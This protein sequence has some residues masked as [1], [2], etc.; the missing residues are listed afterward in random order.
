MEQKGYWVCTEKL[1][2]QAHRWVWI[3]HFG[4]IPEGMHIHHIDEDKSNNEIENLKL[5]TPSEH[6]K[7]H[8]I[9]PDDRAKRRKFLTEIRSKVHQW[10]RSDEGRKKQSEGAIKGWEKRRKNNI[11][12]PRLQ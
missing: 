2:P 12:K 5:M 9:N 8:W 11:D 10:L 4:E 3:N 7:S 6:L 1:Q